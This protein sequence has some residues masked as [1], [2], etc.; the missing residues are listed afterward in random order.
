MKEHPD[1]K[2]RPRRKPKA[3]IKKENKFAFPTSTSTSISISPIHSPN[4]DVHFDALTRSYLPQISPHSSMLPLLNGNLHNTDINF[5]RNLLPA[6]PYSLYHPL[7]Y[8]DDTKLAAD[9]AMFYGSTLYSPNINWGL[10]SCNINNCGCPSNTIPSP[11]VTNTSFSMERHLS[12]SP[13]SEYLK[14]PVYT[15]P[16]DPDK[17]IQTDSDTVNIESNSVSSLSPTAI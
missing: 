8:N 5:N 7:R 13:R 1:Y 10:N 16:T 11:A 12:A 3:F 9:L 6:F 17:Y 4:T 2:Y 14:K 15:L